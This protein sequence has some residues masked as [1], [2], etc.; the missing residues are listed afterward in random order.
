[1][2]LKLNSLDL[3]YLDQC[4]KRWA[5]EPREPEPMEAT[6]ELMKKIFLMRTMGREVGWSFSGVASAW[7]QLFWQNKEITQENMQESVQGILAARQLYKRLPKGE[8]KAHSTKNLTSCL[9]SQLEI[10]STGD[11]LLIY[12]DRY[13]VWVYM[14][15]TPKKIRRSPL[16]A[17]EHYLVHQKIRN[18][19][20]KPF[21][22]VIYYSNTKRRRAS[23][24]RVRSDRSSEECRKIVYNLSDRAKRKIYYP[25][26]GEHCKDCSVKC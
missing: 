12:P 26:F 3:Y 2:G 16:P 23:H 19:H 20:Q 10:S 24:F 13:E 5:E 14:R 7:D 15:S 6:R 22:L 1:M 4:P 21:Y 9:D 18:S 8:I 17:I 25:S 11:F